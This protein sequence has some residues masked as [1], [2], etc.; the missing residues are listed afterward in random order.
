MARPPKK[1]KDQKTSHLHIRLTDE[2][3]KKL[4]LAA[5]REGMDLSTFARTSMIGRARGLGIEI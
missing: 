2:L 4:E 3:K 5:A 1:A